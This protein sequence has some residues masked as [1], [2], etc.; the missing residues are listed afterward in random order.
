MIKDLE[1][2]FLL[3]HIG[4]SRLEIQEMLDEMGFDTID[5]LIQKTIPKSIQT[6]TPLNIGPGIDE[7][8]L[9]KRIKGIASKNK[10]ARSY[11]GTG[12]YGTIT[13][14]VIQRNVLENPGWYTCLL[15]TSPSP[16]DRG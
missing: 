12:Y 11:I 1:Q 13:P 16:R 7:F 10:V 15:Y 5:G 4:P 14:P 8:S 6:K 3:R 2:N 9:L